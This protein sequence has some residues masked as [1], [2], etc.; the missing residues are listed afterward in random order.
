MELLHKKVHRLDLSHFTDCH[1]SLYLQVSHEFAFK[2]QLTK[3]IVSTSQSVV[4]SRDSYERHIVLRSSWSGF[5]D[6]HDTTLK[7]MSLDVS[8]AV[9]FT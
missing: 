4:G 9:F 3:F 5:R 1:M 7:A 8:R 6:R 2:S